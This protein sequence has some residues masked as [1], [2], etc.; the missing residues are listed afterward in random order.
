[1]PVQLYRDALREAH[2]EE[3]RRDDRV[4]ALGE[5][6]GK[7][8]GSFLVTKG[9]LD[10]FGPRRVL[11]TPIAEEGYIGLAIGAA[12]AGLRPI[13]EVMTINFIILAMDQIVNHAAKLRYMSGGQIEM[14]L[15]IRS[16]GGGGL[17]MAAQHSQ[18]LEAWFAHVPG[19]IVVAPSTPAD[20]KGLLKTCV[21][22]DNPVI[23]V[24][25]ELLYFIKGEVPEGEH[26]VPI[27]VADV[28]RPGRHVTVVAWL[29]MVHEAMKAAE[30]LAKEGIEV[31]IV[32]PR[33]LRPLDLE[34]IL[35][36]VRKTNRVV[37]A[38]EG[39]RVASMASEI[40]CRIQAEAFDHLDAPIELV[41]SAEVPMPYARN[42]ERAAIPSAQQIIDAVRKVLA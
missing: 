39:W 33:T 16:P 14:P 34:T 12:M 5:E 1:M 13:A 10:E 2:R 36:S 40:A 37:I 3:M 15:V 27:G 17:Q 22:D 23:F 18:S 6:I 38:Q 26:L 29:K 19:L 4:F 35:A 7:W 8:G 24:E 30:A 41:T 42:L 31:E 9:L 32:D 28:K 25:H 21:R 11:D 20:A